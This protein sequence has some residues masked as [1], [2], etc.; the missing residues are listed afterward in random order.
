MVVNTDVFFGNGKQRIMHE[1][2][3]E[4]AV[5]H[6]VRQVRQLKYLDSAF[7]AMCTITSSS[8][9]LII[10]RLSYNRTSVLSSEHNQIT[11]VLL[12]KC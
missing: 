4:L 2:L 7:S 12:K 8:Y 5:G 3:L 6:V 10:L 11:A 9:Q 1:V